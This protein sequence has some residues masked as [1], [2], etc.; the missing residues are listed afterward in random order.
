MIESKIHIPSRDGFLLDSILLEVGSVPKGVILL[1]GGTGIKKEFY[2][3]FARYVS[4]Q[5]YH[6]LLFDYRGIG[7]SKPKSLRGFKAMNHEWGQKDMAAILDWLQQRYNTFPKFLIGHSAGGQQLGMMDNHN[8]FSKALLISSSTGYWMWLSS[9]YKYFTLF[10]WQVLAPVLLSTV[11]YLPASWFGLGEDLPKGV[12]AEWRSWCM[13]KQYFGKYFGTTIQK[14]FYNEVTIPLHF[15][16]P[17]DDTIATDRT[18]Q[19]LRNFY[20][21]SPTTVEKIVLNDHNL[22]QI[23]HLGFFSRKVKDKLWGKALSFLNGK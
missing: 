13:N 10:I 12:A 2:L 15:L 9:P 16:F 20:T 23:G 5:G 19:S 18:V 21:K 6:V 11:G 17:E 4:E 3:N 14:Q 22:Q 7:G 1:A 8:Q